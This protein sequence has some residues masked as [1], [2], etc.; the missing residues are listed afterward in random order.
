MK[1]K[2]YGWTATM[3]EALRVRLGDQHWHCQCRAVVA[4]RSLTAVGVI[5]GRSYRQLFNLC[6]TGNDREIE[7]ALARPG[8]VFAASINQG[9]SRTYIEAPEIIG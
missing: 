2:V 3:P 1:L 6:E 5:V 4:A 9:G 7:I 8:V